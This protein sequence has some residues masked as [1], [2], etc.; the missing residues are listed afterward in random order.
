MKTKALN[1]NE[2]GGMAEG[3]DNQCEESGAGDRIIM[4]PAI[5]RYWVAGVDGWSMEQVEDGSWVR[6]DDHVAAMESMLSEVE[7]L[8][9]AIEEL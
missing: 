1:R 6:Y 7:K 2:R 3:A 5:Q 4:I 9:L 8:K